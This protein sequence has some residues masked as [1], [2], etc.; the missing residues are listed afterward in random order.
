MGI[1]ITGG[2][3][4]SVLNALNNPRIRKHRKL[5]K[6]IHKTIAQKNIIALMTVSSRFEL[7]LAY[8]TLLRSR[9]KMI[10]SKK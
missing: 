6:G 4:A 8:F 2:Y 5:I 7:P 9:P 1:N 10:I 3:Y